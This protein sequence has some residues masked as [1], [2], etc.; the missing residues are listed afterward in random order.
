VLD[1]GGR[2]LGVIPVD[3]GVYCVRN[4]CPHQ[5]AQLCR[6]KLIGTM[7]PSQPTE[8]QYGLRNHVLRCPVH[9]WE[10]DIRTGE[11]VFGISTKRAVTY[12]TKIE[13]GILY[14]ELPSARGAGD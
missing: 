6:G 13:E 10:F 14:I 5:G 8:Y 4:D 3:D 11:A 12:A 7:L 2:S 1:V 9:G